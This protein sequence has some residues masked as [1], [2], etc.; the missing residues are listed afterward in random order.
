MLNN[1]E[2]IWSQELNGFDPDYSSSLVKNVSNKYQE[3]FNKEMKKII[4]QGVLEG[5]FFKTRI[6]DLEYICIGA[7][8]Y[9]AHSPK[10]KVSISSL[11]RMWNFL[12]EIVLI[13]F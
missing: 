7:E 10:E 4:T 8:S 3:L 5:G 6:K 13:R 2:I 9:D 11:Q 1:I 12:R